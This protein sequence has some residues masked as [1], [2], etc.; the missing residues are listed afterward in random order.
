MK[1]NSRIGHQIQKGSPLSLHLVSNIGLLIHYIIYKIV[2]IFS[3]NVREF[4][5]SELEESSR[6]YSTLIGK[7]GFG[8]VDKGIFHHLPIA[9]KLLNKVCILL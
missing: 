8:K 2:V 7:E 4:R 9:V 1:N 5:R 6:N 3:V